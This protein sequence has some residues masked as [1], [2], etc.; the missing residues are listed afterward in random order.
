MEEPIHS[1]E[2]LFHQLGLNTK[3]EAV[4]N[5]IDK[6]APLPNGV[7]IYEANFWSDSQASCLKQMIDEDAD[8]AEIVDQLSVLLS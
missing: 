3:D 2:S 8:W 5:F 4:A 1:M 6:N 7:K